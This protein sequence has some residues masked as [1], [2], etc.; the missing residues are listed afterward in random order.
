MNRISTNE[1]DESQA[2]YQANLRMAEDEGIIGALDCHDLDAL[3]MPTFVSFHLPAIAGLP[4]VTAPLGF[5]PA[6]TPF[7][8]NC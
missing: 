4:I 6:N 5:F 3:V 7:V 2:A 1:S 8:M